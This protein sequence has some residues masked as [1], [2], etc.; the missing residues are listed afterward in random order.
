MILQRFSV[1]VLLLT[2]TLICTAQQ[3]HFVYLQTENGQPFYIKMNKEVTSSTAAGYLILPRLADGDYNVTVGFPK[4]EFPEEEFHL[5]VDKDN[6]GFLLKN[7]GEKGWGLFNLQS[8][9][10]VMGS[11]SQSSV[12]ANKELQDDPFSRMLANVVKD[13]TLLE[14]NVVV[15]EDKQGAANDSVVKEPRDLNGSVAT[16][17]VAAA[18]NAVPPVQPS[19]QVRSADITRT[20]FNEN[21]EGIELVYIDNTQAP[22][23][24]IRVFIPSERQGEGKSAEDV[25]VGKAKERA[26]ISD[27]AVTN[28]DSL[29]NQSPSLSAESAV[30]KSEPTDAAESTNGGSSSEIATA[31]GDSILEESKTTAEK[32][33]GVTPDEPA[34]VIEKATIE[35]P[36]KDAA[37]ASEYPKVV[38]SSFANSDCSVFATN[39][40]FIKLRKKMA[41]EKNNEDMLKEAKRL[42]ESK[43][44]STEQ[45]KNLSFLFAND[46]GKYQFFAAAYPFTSDTNLYAT[47]QTQL[48]DPYYVNKFKAMIHK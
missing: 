41:G 39:D 25:A 15:N 9:G 45:I 5:S 31:P 27:A 1:T 30:N 32:S 14:K 29:V 21:K 2:L 42:L 40:D 18:T 22:S 28:A 46:Q 17:T 38:T 33:A 12:V 13:S 6:K 16:D 23:D 19:T 43:C 7:F 34:N 11:S 44:F 4:R 48:H 36:G 26:G 3:V 20:L 47:L 10:I 37:V 8:F 35:P 24:T